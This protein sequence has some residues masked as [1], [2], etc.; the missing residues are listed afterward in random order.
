MTNFKSF[1]PTVLCGPSRM[2]PKSYF[3]TQVL[4]SGDDEFI[5]AKVWLTREL[6]CNVAASHCDLI[7]RER[8]DQ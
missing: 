4:H 5:L 6:L 1:L 8:L 7:D 2:M 3:P